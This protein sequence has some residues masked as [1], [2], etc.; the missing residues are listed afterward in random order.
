[1]H[2]VIVAGNHGI[3]YIRY[4]GFLLAMV[5]P[6]GDSTN[7]YRLDVGSGKISIVPWGEQL[8]RHGKVW[9]STGVHVT[10]GQ[11]R[12]STPPQTATRPE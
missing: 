7:C 11:N 10:A 5:M 9:L 3:G 8:R 12:D 6:E 1:M 4:S 2:C